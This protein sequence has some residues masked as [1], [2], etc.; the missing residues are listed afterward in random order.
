MS[1]SHP[2]ITLTTSPADSRLEALFVNS[3]LAKHV[4]LTMGKVYGNPL[5]LIHT[6]IRGR[7]NDSAITESAGGLSVIRNRRAT[8]TQ[9]AHAIHLA[10]AGKGPFKKGKHSIL[11]LEGRDGFLVAVH[12][13]WLSSFST[14]YI[15]CH[16]FDGYSRWLEGS[17]VYG[18]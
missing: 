7:Q 6:V 16:R 18:N 4:D 17:E 12:V 3:N 14:W 5:H 9:L 15:N 2:V 13:F 10:R 1:T 11:Y 8:P